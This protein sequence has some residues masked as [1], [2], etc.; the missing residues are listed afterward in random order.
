[1]NLTS[2]ESKVVVSMLRM[3]SFYTEVYNGSLYK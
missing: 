2:S 3:E 1:M